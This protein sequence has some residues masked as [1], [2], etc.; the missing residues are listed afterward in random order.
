MADVAASMVELR[1]DR[2]RQKALLDHL[3][4]HGLAIVAGE[5]SR[6]RPLDGQMQ[7]LRREPCPRRLTA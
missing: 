2:K 5:R 4:P 6:K 1:P 3:P 7:R